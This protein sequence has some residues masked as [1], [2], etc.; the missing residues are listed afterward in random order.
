MT[1]AAVLAW[2]LLAVAELLAVVVAELLA[3][4]AAGG[5]VM[6]VGT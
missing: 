6:G 4:I 1:A 2:L 3:V 5:V